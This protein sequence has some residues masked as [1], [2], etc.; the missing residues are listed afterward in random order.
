MPDSTFTGILRKFM[1]F[2]Y[3]NYKSDYYY[4]VDAF[5][6]KVFTRFSIQH[7]FNQLVDS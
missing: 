2:G 4:F 1:E 5:V 6:N 7:P 3:P